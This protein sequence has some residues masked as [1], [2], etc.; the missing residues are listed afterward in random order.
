MREKRKQIGE[1][2]EAHR[3]GVVVGGAQHSVDQG[4]AVVGPH[5]RQVHKIL[6][7]KARL[8]VHHL[9]WGKDRCHLSA[10]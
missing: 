7:G 2:R 8:A 4:G 6:E 5:I 10:L 1:G 3:V 9:A